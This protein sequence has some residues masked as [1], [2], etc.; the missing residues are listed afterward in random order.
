MTA[1]RIAGKMGFG[2]PLAI[3][4]SPA[5]LGETATLQ[6]GIGDH[7]HQGVTMKAMPG[8]A[9]EMIEAEFFLELLV[10]LFANPTR[11]DRGGERL[12]ID[13]CGQV[14]EIVFSFARTAAFAD[15]PGFLAGYMLHSFVADALRR[16]VGDA[17]ADGGEGGGQRSLGSL[18]PGQA[19]PLRLFEHV[20]GG[21]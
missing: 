14:G 16:T 19:P 18:A 9:L 6:V 7:C 20:L 2:G 21:Y 17:H 5:R 15:E 1:R 3:L 10:R 11:L 12:E 4:F 8:A 13:I